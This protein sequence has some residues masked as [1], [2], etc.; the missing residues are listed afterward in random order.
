MNGMSYYVVLF[1]E[2]QAFRKD[3]IILEAVFPDLKEDF[4]HVL[5]SFA[6]GCFMQDRSEAFID[7]V[8]GLWFSL[9]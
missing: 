4:D 6:N 8:V 3:D 7:A 5:N 9:R 2:I 1:D